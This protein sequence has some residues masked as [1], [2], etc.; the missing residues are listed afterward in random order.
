MLTCIQS[1]GYYRSDIHV[2]TH[3][4]FS[5]PGHPHVTILSLQ[6]QRATSQK[7]LL[8]TEFWTL[9][10]WAYK[11]ARRGLHT[12]ELCLPVSPNCSIPNS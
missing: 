7:E 8:C 5:S 6:A 10:Y 4:V 2:E 12:T 9:Y 11:L 3:V 1:F